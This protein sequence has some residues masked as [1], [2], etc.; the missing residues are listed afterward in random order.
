MHW[1]WPTFFIALPIG[2]VAGIVGTV[3]IFAVLATVM[4]DE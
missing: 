1:S 3:V 4:S 2:A